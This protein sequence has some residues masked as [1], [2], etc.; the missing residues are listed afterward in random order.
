M[1]CF[2]CAL[3]LK[4]WEVNDDPWVQHAQ[5]SGDCSYL[6]ICKSTDFIEDAQEEFINN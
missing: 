3:N 1:R 5:W 2:S 6:R 4:N